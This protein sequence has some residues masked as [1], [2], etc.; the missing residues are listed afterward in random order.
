MTR[1]GRYPRWRWDC[2]PFGRQN[3]HLI[4]LWTGHG[5]AFVRLVCPEPEPWL[6]E[7][8]CRDGGRIERFSRRCDAKRWC[9]RM[10]AGGQ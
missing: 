2:S 3:I 10:L 7:T 8:L 9:E 1:G 6:A 5:S 4:H